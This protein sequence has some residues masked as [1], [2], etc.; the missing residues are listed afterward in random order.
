MNFNEDLP[1]HKPKPFIIMRWVKR[2]DKQGF[3]HG[4]EP[5]LT[6][7]KRSHLLCPPCLQ[8]S[9]SMPGP[10]TTRASSTGALSTNIR[11]LTKPN[12]RRQHTDASHTSSSCPVRPS[13]GP[14][15]TVT[16]D[17]DDGTSNS[18]TTTPRS[19]LSKT[20]PTTTSIASTSSK[21]EAR[22]LFLP[23]STGY[24]QIFAVPNSCQRYKVKSK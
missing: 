11:R 5:D 10:P 1:S 9:A 16:H 19:T 4:F 24:G 17:H 23:P 14:P 22:L 3:R 2:K 13:A 8:G 6:L 21:N 12:H 18:T 20:A 7:A 15:G